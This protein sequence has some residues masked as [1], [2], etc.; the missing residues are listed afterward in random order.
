MKIYVDKKD[1]YKNIPTS[2]IHN[3]PKLETTQMPINRAMD[4]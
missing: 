3:T 1:L 2:F 4:E